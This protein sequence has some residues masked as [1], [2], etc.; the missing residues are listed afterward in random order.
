MAS[1]IGTW[2]RYCCALY[3]EVATA[4]LCC[5]LKLYDSMY[6]VCVHAFLG[7]YA[8]DSDFIL[9]GMPLA[10]WDRKSGVHAL[11]APL[12][13]ISCGLLP[14]PT[15]LG[16]N[17]QHSNDKQS[18]F[19]WANFCKVLLYT[20]LCWNI[21]TVAEN[22]VFVCYVMLQFLISGWVNGYILLYVLC[23]FFR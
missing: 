20:L 5:G 10:E 18:L 12:S 1:R 23:V 8:M 15:A 2:E 7:C 4:W 3:C 14:L 9:M 11:S 21:L 6:L 17:P 22:A 13:H 16:R 19:D